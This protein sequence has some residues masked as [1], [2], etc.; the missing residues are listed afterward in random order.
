MQFSQYLRNDVLVAIRNTLED[1]SAFKEFLAKITHDIDHTDIYDTSRRYFAFARRHI[2]ELFDIIEGGD[3]LHWPYHNTLFNADQKKNPFEIANIYRLWYQEAISKYR[4]KLTLGVND[5]LRWLHEVHL[6]IYI[7]MK[8]RDYLWTANA[9]TMRSNASMSHVVTGVQSLIASDNTKKNNKFDSNKDNPLFDITT[10]A[11]AFYSWDKKKLNYIF[12]SEWWIGRYAYEKDST[13]FEINGKKIPIAHI[14]TRD[15][16][17]WSL[18][19]K[20]IRKWMLE[21]H[22]LDYTRLKIV[23]PEG[24]DR[25]EKKK[26]VQILFNALLDKLG[27]G[28]TW[29]EQPSYEPVTHPSFK[30]TKDRINV[31][32]GILQ[33]SINEVQYPIE[34]Q[35]FEDETSYVFRDIDLK[36]PI[37]HANYKRSQL[38]WLLPIFFPK[39]LYG[40]VHLKEFKTREDKTLK[41]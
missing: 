15:K 10:S 34:I 18:I 30:K 37:Y 33:A 2:Q 5:S 6:L 16:D 20:T 4:S 7:A 35:I 38:Q 40:D 9:K 25:T 1:E 22:H 13:E 11:T 21:S 8:Y 3:E 32:K 31:W 12:P 36:S 23:L 14:S 24:W 19:L 29:I 27:D 41:S 28:M 26:T 17:P 39:H